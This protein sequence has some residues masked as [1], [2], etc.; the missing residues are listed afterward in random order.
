[1]NKRGDHT[2]A[3]EFYLRAFRSPIPGPAGDTVFHQHERS[4]G[5]WSIQRPKDVLKEDNYFGSA[6]KRMQRIEAAAAPLFRDDGFVI[7]RRQ[8]TTEERQRLADFVAL[9]DPRS[10][11]LHS[12]LS[13]TLEFG[14]RSVARDRQRDYKAQ[15]G[16]FRDDMAELERRTGMSYSDMKPCDFDL[17]PFDILISRPAVV[18]GAMQAVDVFSP[19]FAHAAWTFFCA[20]DHDVFITSD[21]PVS[22]GG[23]TTYLRYFCPLTNG[24]ALAMDIHQPNGSCCFMDAP[25]GLVA[26]ANLETWR[27]APRFRFAPRRDF[28]GHEHIARIDP[29]VGA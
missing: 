14:L 22:A 12:A 8:P 23:D 21:R 29:T 19:I 6:D 13:A 11:E 7:Q 5:L 10:P 27:R 2:G 4:T 17:T 25:R 1:M 9:M 3:P 16:L 26:G 20:A 18:A 15:P 28:T 24:V